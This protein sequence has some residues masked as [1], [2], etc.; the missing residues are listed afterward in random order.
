MRNLWVRLGVVMSI[1]EDEER[2]I[3][4]SGDP[5]EA[6]SAVLEI[7]YERRF[8]A[9]GDT[10]VPYEVVADYNE[11]YGTSYPEKTVEMCL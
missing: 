8:T 7:L 6:A 4:G 10:Y 9:D 3:L 11:K 1:T 2:R 5:H